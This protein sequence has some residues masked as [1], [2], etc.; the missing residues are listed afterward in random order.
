MG[1]GG[2]TSFSLNYEKLVFSVNRYILLQLP[3]VLAFSL[4]EFDLEP[5]EEELL[6]LYFIKMTVGTGK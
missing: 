4:W 3:F 2:V 5:R 6:L 1:L